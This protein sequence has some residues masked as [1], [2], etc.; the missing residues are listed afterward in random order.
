MTT[1][2]RRALQRPMLAAA[3]LASVVAM[4]LP[5]LAQTSMGSREFQQAELSELSPALRSEVERRVAQAPGN[6]PRG[7]LESM[8]LNEL[9]IREPASRIVGLDL[10]RGVVVIQQPAGAMKAYTFNKQEGLRVMGEVS[11]AR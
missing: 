10:G 9:Q 5:S 6:T 4:P 7:V 8:L 1:N 3:A 2:L 11:L